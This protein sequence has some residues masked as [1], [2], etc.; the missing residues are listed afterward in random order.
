MYIDKKHELCISYFSL[1]LSGMTKYFTMS[2]GLSTDNER[3][4]S[5][6]EEK[7][8]GRGAEEKLNFPKQ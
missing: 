7:K 1:K 5:C 3:L 8:L 6:L 4:P 2:Q